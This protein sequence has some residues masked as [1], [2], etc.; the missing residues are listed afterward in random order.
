MTILDL[1]ELPGSRASAR[2]PLPD[3]APRAATIEAIV[4]FGVTDL[5]G[6]SLAIG[7]KGTQMI[8]DSFK[9]QGLGLD[10]AGSGGAAGAG[11]G[12]GALEI[13]SINQNGGAGAFKLLDRLRFGTWC[14][15]AT[16]IANFKY[17]VQ[18]LGYVAN[19]ERDA[20]NNAWPA[21][22]GFATNSSGTLTHQAYLSE[23]SASVRYV[24]FD[25]KSVKPG[26]WGSA[27]GTRTDIT[28][29]V[30]TLIAAPGVGKYLRIHTLFVYALGVTNATTQYVLIG[31]DPAL[32]VNDR[33]FWFRSNNFTERCK[34]DVRLTDIDIPC[35]ENKGVVMS[36]PAGMRHSGTN[37]KIV[38]TVGAE[39]CNIGVGNF[40][41]KNGAV[42]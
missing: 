18:K 7:R 11:T 17:D 25:H 8:V 42:A 27:D 5:G 28:S 21:S 33:I 37:S 23:A 4:G 9:A 29:G 15:A 16:G 35:P 2:R 14:S 6:R 39:I 10:W 32:A 36:S 41:N 1:D 12:D 19:T 3:T 30:T 26:A 22:I 40:I 38:V 31:S 20:S 34:I 13:R 24:G